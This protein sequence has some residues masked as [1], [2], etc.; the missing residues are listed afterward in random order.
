MSVPDDLYIQ[1]TSGLLVVADPQTLEH[2]SAEPLLAVVHRASLFLCQKC[3][4]EGE[5][6]VCL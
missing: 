6:E 2:F 3:L 1:S 5:E 4:D